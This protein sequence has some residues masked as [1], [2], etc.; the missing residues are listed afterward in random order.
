MAG[1]QE[2]VLKYLWGYAAGAMRVNSTVVDHIGFTRAG[3]AP[4]A[5]NKCLHSDRVVA[6]ERPLHR[7]P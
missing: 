7:S 6:T 2:T 4:F 1:Y 3:G 5:S